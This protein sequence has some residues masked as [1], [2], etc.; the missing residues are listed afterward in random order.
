MKGAGVDAT[1]QLKHVVDL[2]HAMVCQDE[3]PP[4]VAR[5]KN[6]SGE[7]IKVIVEL[8]EVKDGKLVFG[9]FEMLQV[10]LE[11]CKVGLVGVWYYFLGDQKGVN[12][13]VY[14]QLVVTSF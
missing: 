13:I 1:N 10:N 9:H 4:S 8:R 3:E 6:L 5:V 11:A 12:Y 14:A 2:L 7:C